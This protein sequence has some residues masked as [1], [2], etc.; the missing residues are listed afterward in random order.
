MIVGFVLSLL[1]SHS[2]SRNHSSAVSKDQFPPTYQSKIVHIYPHDPEAFTQ[3]LAYHGNF[4]Y[5][6]TGLWGQSS[7]RKVDLATGQVLQIRLL[8]DRY[9]GEALTFWQDKLIQL[10]WKEQIGFVYNVKSFQP[11]GSFSYSTEGWGLTQDGQRLIM[12]DGTSTLHFL[13]PLTFQPIGQLQVTN[14]SNPVVYLNELEYVKG[15]I[16]ANVW[17]SNRIA[18]V[19]PQTGQVTSSIDLTALVNTMGRSTIDVPNGI[20]YDEIQRPALGSPES[21]GRACSKFTLTR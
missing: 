19:S 12:S 10:T 21:I 6:S 1:I 5:E 3:G 14:G 20:A 18:R 13:D 8:D 11:I 17:Q 2:V 4:L 15:E 16:Y 7:I 9:F